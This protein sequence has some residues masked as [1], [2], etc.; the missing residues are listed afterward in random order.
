MIAEQIDRLREVVPI[1][2]PFYNWVK[3]SRCPEV[4][5]YDLQPGCT[6]LESFQGAA[7]SKDWTVRGNEVL[8][9]DC[10]KRLNAQDMVDEG[11]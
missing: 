11:R 4:L 7:D 2:E 10:L 6:E 9:R 3:C 5:T 1:T 8:C